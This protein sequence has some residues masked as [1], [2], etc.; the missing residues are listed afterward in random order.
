M[1]ALDRYWR[2]LL[3]LGLPPLLLFSVRMFG[4]NK[5]GL[6]LAFQ[7]FAW[8]ELFGFASPLFGNISSMFLEGTAPS[9]PPSEGSE[10]LFSFFPGMVHSFVVPRS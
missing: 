2:S 1:V 8:L 6:V 9:P 10:W 3:R 5:E 7:S 4:K